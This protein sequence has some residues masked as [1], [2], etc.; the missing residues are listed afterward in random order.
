MQTRSLE[1]VT[2]LN[3]RYQPEEVVLTVDLVALR[4]ALVTEVVVAVGTLEAARVP[5]SVLNF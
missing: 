4:E 5:R 1:G 3:S 2:Y